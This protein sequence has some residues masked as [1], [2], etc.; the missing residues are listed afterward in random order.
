MGADFLDKQSLWYMFVVI[1]FVFCFYFKTVFLAVNPAG[2]PDS[3]RTK[4]DTGYKKGRI[5]G[6]TLIFSTSEFRL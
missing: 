3:R 4:P 6:A 5:S 2:Y 1:L